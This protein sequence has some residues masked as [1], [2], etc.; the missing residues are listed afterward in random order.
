[1]YTNLYNDSL[2][3]GA[4]LTMQL[5]WTVAYMPIAWY[6]VLNCYCFILF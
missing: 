5:F 6:I 2:N 1:M 4:L 3:V